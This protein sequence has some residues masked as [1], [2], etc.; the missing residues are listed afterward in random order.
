MNTV[1]SS[2]GTT[3]AYDRAGSGPAVILVAGAFS[4]RKDPMMVG[5]AAAMAG[6]FTTYLYDRRGR[7]DSGD[8]APYAPQREIDDLDALIVEAGGRAVVFGGSS[9][10]ALAL[11]AAAA[12]SAI[13]HLVVFEPP[14]VVGRDRGPVPTAAELDALVQSGRRGE[15]VEQ[16]LVQGAEIPAEVVAGMKADPSWSHV[17]SIAH[18]LVYEAAIVGPGPIPDSRLGRISVPTLVLH[19]SDSAPR[20]HAAAKAVAAAIPDS[21]LQI[22]EGQAHG[23][24]DPKNVASVLTNFVNR[25]DPA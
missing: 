17:E 14:Y 16:F 9:G 2:D 18:T 1:N 24:L 22:L 23:A 6:D 7:G 10:G 13:T 5:L 19:G 8:T 15:A 20:M 11:E 12:G 21:T 25:T 3:I 4:D